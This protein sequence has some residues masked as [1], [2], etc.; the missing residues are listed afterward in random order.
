MK[1]TLF[2]VVLLLNDGKF[3]TSTVLVDKCP[4]KPQVEATYERLRLAHEFKNWSALCTTFNF[5]KPVKK[6]PLRNNNEELKV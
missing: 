2:I 1:A 5:K 6:P 3:H 4:P